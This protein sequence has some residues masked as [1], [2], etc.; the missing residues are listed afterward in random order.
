MICTF[1]GHK[2]APDSLKNELKSAIIGLI[3]LYD[4][5]MFYVGNN[6]SFDSLVQRTLAEIQGG[7]TRRFVLRGAFLSL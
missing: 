3:D 4:V 1:F 5:K 7:A 2:D 6:G